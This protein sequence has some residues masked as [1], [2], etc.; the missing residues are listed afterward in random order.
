MPF[1]RVDHLLV[2]KS[3]YQRDINNIKHLI[4]A[5]CYITDRVDLAYFACSSQFYF[6]LILLHFTFSRSYKILPYYVY[7]Y[8]ILIR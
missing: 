4:F 3:N 7:Y 1:E 5:Y 8:C 6:L 2:M